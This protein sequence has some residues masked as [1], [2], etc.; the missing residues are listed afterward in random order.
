MIPQ[1]F[2]PFIYTY[3]HKL[4]FFSHRNASI[5]IT[6]LLF[7]IVLNLIACFHVSMLVLYEI[8]FKVFLQ[9]GNNA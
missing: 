6:I 7:T 8:K 3:A 5:L 1:Y 4:N 9:T 2:I